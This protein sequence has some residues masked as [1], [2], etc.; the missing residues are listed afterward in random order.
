MRP[1]DHGEMRNGGLPDWLYGR[2]FEIRS[3]EEEYLHYV[4]ELYGEITD[5]CEGL[6]YKDGGPIIGVQLENEYQHSAAPWEITYPGARE[7]LT[8]AEKNAEVTYVQI[9][10]TDGVN[11]HAEEGKDHMATLKQIA[12]NMVWTCLCIQ[13]QDGEMQLLLMKAVYL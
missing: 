2:T 13:L 9:S 11:R 8:V 6:L 4:D 12:L 1:F 10:E 7:E 5:K 3:N